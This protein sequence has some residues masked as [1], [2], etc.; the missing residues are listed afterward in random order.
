MPRLAGKLG[1]LEPH[2]P[3]HLVPGKLID[4]G[5]HE[6][7]RQNLTPAGWSERQFPWEAKTQ[8]NTKNEFSQK[9]QTGISKETNILGVT[10][11]ELIK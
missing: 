1:G 11:N 6:L 9:T 4:G 8:L 3:R 2:Q 5:K 10:F 7:C